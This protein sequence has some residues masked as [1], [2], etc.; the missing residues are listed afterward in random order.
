M[1]AERKYEII[2]RNLQEVVGEAELREILAK[3][4]LK[5]YLGTATTG[6]PHIGYFV[7]MMKIADFLE[8]GCEVTVLFADLHAYLDNMKT[9]WELLE[10]RTQY[11]EHVI[12]Q[13]LM[14]TGAD[15]SKLK[16]VVGTD[17]QLSREY[18]LD[19]YRLSAIT[20]E[21]DAKKAGSEVVKQ[22]E[23]PKIGGLLYPL[24]QALDEEYLGV[25][26]QF[27]G[28]DQRKIFMFAAEYLPKIGYK[29]RIH[30]MNPMVPGLS[31]GKMSSSEPESKIDLLDSEE[32]IMKKFSKA[33]CPAGEVED[34][35]VLAL[36]R[37]VLFPLL[38]KKGRRFVIKRPEK[39]GGNVEF[40]SYHELES[41][42]KNRAV[43]PMDLKNAV[44]GEFC[45]LLGPV[46]EHFASGNMKGL[47][48]EAYPDE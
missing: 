15:L 46:R 6:R 40:A 39:F 41:A 38:E 12:K 19:V 32:E 26:A 22:V 42:Y 9:S 47:V 48:K 23:S 27:G 5:V 31:G 37:I 24:L 8:A 35:G 33:F 4:N 25:D 1:D 28:V 30:L 18:T 20:T 43:H 21:H 7:P 10:K 2:T 17:V 36:C 45:V 16:F 29:K 34:N 14:I 3:R 11:Y 44:A 13:L